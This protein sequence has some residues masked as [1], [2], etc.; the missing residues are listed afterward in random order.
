[1]AVMQRTTAVG[2]F[3]D[4]ARAQQ[5]L[6]ELR[7]AG[8]GESQLG[9]VAPGESGQDAAH[10]PGDR[11][12]DKNS[13]LPEGAVTGVAAGLGA[14]A[15]WALGIAAGLLP[16]IGPIVAG[17]ILASVLA[18]AVGAGAAGGIVGALI[19]L[20]LP[21]EDARYYEGEV[22][23]GRTLITVDAGNRYEEAV[24]ILDRYGATRRPTAATV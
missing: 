2:V 24:A 10:T 14:G 6:Q 22:R 9:L 7:R 17:G 18:S 1:M 20:G 13:K 5:A 11:P 21:D 3:S 19:G 23:S 8:F 15:L 4:R 16:G 12:I